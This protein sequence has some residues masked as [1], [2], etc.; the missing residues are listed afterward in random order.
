MVRKTRFQSN[1]W[2]GFTLIELL[3]VIAIIAILAALLLPVLSKTKEQGVTTICLNHHRQINLAS[4]IYAS[5]NDDSF[6]QWGKDGPTPNALL[7]DPVVT[8]WPDTLLSYVKNPKIYNCPRRAGLTDLFGIGI[9]Y[10]FIGVYGDQTSGWINRIR[11]AQLNNPG[12]TV[13]FGDDQ[14]VIN[15]REPDPDQWLPKLTGSP[16]CIVFRTP[17]DLPQYVLDPYRIIQ[18]HAGRTVVS[19]GDGRSEIVKASTVG[20]QY[21]EGHSLAKW[22]RQ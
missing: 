17:P 3:V 7:P 5:D 4:T 20:L 16:Y 6:V 10:P 2:K 18:R 1:G 22:D 14:D 21:P 8:Y 15:P 9:N 11:V 12:E 13:V 19:F